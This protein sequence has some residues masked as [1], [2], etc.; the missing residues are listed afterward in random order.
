MDPMSIRYPFVS[1]VVGIS[2]YQQ[3]ASMLSVGAEVVIEHE[4]D[5]PYDANACV[6][7]VDGRT[8]GYL[9][10]NLAQRVVNGGS[11]RLRGE[12]V[13]KHD[14]KATIG[15]EIRVIGPFDAHPAAIPSA[16]TAQAVSG[17][18]VVVAKRSRR[19][20]GRLERVDRE[21]R[22]VIVN[23]GNGSIPYP[24]GLVDIVEAR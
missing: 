3:A 4:P 24:D 5:N 18:L 7:H 2:Q 15:V 17:G 1:K 13:N 23:D 21:G 16:A 14:T 22:S 12:V 19:V 8:I 6:V 10:R 20:L 11:T 9:P